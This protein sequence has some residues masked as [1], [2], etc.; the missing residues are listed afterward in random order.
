[1]SHIVFSSSEDESENDLQQQIDRLSLEVEKLN[2]GKWVK[3][4]ETRILKVVDTF[5]VHIFARHEDKTKIL[6]KQNFTLRKELQDLKKEM[7]SMIQ[8]TVNKL[9]NVSNH[10]NNYLLNRIKNT[11][12]GLQQLTMNVENGLRAARI[13]IEKKNELLNEKIN[14]LEKKIYMDMETLIDQLQRE[15]YSMKKQNLLLEPGARLV[16]HKSIAEKIA[17]S[18]MGAKTVTA[19]GTL[20]CSIQF[21]K[22]IA[23]FNTNANAIHPT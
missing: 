4:Q 17:G 1:M 14:T 12:E 19:N 3:E 6:E 9:T 7:K 18:A 23:T 16:G 22:K 20:Q 15:V 8:N 13:F 21:I 11:E 2:T 5:I 10:N